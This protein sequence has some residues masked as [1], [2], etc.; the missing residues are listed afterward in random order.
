MGV[1]FDL[2]MFVQRLYQAAAGFWEEALNTGAGESEEKGAGSGGG[3]LKLASEL[4]F[5]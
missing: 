2:Y 1:V 4:E 3:G 5:F